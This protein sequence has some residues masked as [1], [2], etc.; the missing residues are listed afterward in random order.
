MCATSRTYDEA[1]KAKALELYAEHGPSHVERE[2]GI[3]KG[4]VSKWAQA[5]GT[6][7]RFLENA[8][9]R[10]KASCL[11]WAERRA[12]LVDRMGAVAEAALERVEANLFET[13]RVR[14]GFD[15]DGDPEFDVRYTANS[16]KGY[17]TT[18]A[19]L[20]DKAQL[21]SGDATARTEVGG[22]REDLVAKVAEFDELAERRARVA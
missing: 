5:A 10:V 17:A 4:T 8:D 13:E 2:M 19:I 1:T 22:K 3:P 7:T 11:R 12:D 15:D 20:I 9:A 14:V 18:M 21:L 6:E 16:A